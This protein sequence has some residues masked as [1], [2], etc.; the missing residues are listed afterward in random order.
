MYCN[1]LRPVQQSFTKKTGNPQ[2]KFNSAGFMVN[3]NENF[4]I[5]E[6]VLGKDVAYCTVICQWHFISCSR[7]HTKDI[8]MNERETLKHYTKRF[9][10]HTPDMIMTKL[11]NLW[12]SHIPVLALAIGGSGGKCTISTLYQHS[13]VSI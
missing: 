6:K 8:N 5:I 4:N 10:T 1:V 2:Y 13:G 9:V 3:E 11:Q 12:R 7:N